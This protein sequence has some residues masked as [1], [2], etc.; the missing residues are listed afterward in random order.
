M[1]VSLTWPWCCCLCCLYSDSYAAAAAVTCLF[2]AGICLFIS[3]SCSNV[4]HFYTITKYNWP[5]QCLA[6]TCHNCHNVIGIFG[7]C[8]QDTIFHVFPLAFDC[9]EGNKVTLVYCC[10][11]WFLELGQSCLMAESGELPEPGSRLHQL[12]F[13]TDDVAQLCWHLLCLNYSSTF[14]ST[15]LYS[16]SRD[17]L[18]LG[19]MT[20]LILAFPFAIDIPV[21]YC[22]CYSSICLWRN[23]LSRLLY[24]KG[25]QIELIF[26]TIF[27][28]FYEF[29]LRVF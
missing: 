22:Y 3:S 27:A 23:L 29:T 12:I 9:L 1:Y 7:I 5:S 13:A 24:L 10:R 14:F 20:W 4:C 8:F 25:K 21:S 28:L 15:D 18:I 6:L 11:S 19:I 17:Q 16:P 2:T 26:C